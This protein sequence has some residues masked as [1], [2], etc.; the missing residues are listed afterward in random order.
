MFTRWL[1]PTKLLLTLLGNRM[2]ILIITV[3]RKNDP[4]L[5]EAVSDFTDRISHYAD[6]EWKI[7]PQSD[8]EK[9]GALI[10]G[11]LNK[12]DYTVLLDEKGKAVD[13]PALATFIQ[14]RLNEATHR[15]VFVIGGAYGVS[16][17]VRNVARATISL[18][19]LTFPHQLVRLIL[20]EQIY[21]A[22]TIVRGEKYHHS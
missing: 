14:K 9:E 7:L 15:L 1:K 22:F 11:A 20:A 3:G 12:R 10:V 6:I 13:S 8:V 18:S 17:N 5:D 16:A 4:G 21:R 19:N 2:K